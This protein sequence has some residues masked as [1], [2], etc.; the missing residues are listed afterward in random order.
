MIGDLIDE[1][2]SSV[3]VERDPELSLVGAALF[4]EECFG[5]RL[6]DADL[7]AANLGG[8]AELRAFLAARERP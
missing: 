3:P 5:I 1:Y 2:F 7:T 4:A 8:P 6:P